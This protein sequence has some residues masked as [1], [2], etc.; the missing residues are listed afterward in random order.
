[1]NI[2]INRSDELWLRPG[3]WDRNYFVA[4]VRLT[5]T[6]RRI[7]I[8]IVGSGD[9]RR[10]LRISFGRINLFA[11]LASLTDRARYV[12]K[13]DRWQF[14]RSATLA[15]AGLWRPGVRSAGGSSASREG[16]TPYNTWVRIFDENPV[17]HRGRHEQRLKNLSRR[18]VLSCLIYFTSFDAF[19]VERLARSVGEQIYPHWQLVVAC[20][21]QVISAIRDAL[22]SFGIDFPSV[23]FI[24]V[25]ADVASTLNALAAEATGDFVLQLPTGSLLRQHALLELAL[26]LDRHPDTEL[27]YSD[28]DR[29]DLRGT[30]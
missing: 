10:P 6:I 12:L 11:R 23:Q 14:I 5:G 7:A 27:V 15:L 3:A 24:P 4:D 25:S 30:S 29:V 2:S 26:L 8:I 19:A 17:S 28:E 20:P 16:E 9:V 18:P 13:R 21:L 1:M 22:Q